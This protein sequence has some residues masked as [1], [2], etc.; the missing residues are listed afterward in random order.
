MKSKKPLWYYCE[1]YGFNVYY[2][3]GWTKEEFSKY[4]QRYYKHTPEK[5][6]GSLG[7][8][9]ELIRNDTGASDYAIWTKDA[10]NNAIIAHEAVHVACFALGKRGID[11]RDSAGE[12]M[13]YTV[14]ALIR[15]SK[16]NKGKR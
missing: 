14:E 13:A 2:F 9:M 7:L 1:L 16:I 15:N 3:L 12:A 11:I 10:A 8:T 6:G 4:C 5:L